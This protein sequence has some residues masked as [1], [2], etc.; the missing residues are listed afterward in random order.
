MIGYQIFTAQVLACIETAICNIAVIYS[1]FVPC[2]ATKVWGGWGPASDTHE[3]VIVSSSCKVLYVV[4]TCTDIL[5]LLMEV[6]T[7]T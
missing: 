4:H 2:Y 5:Y 1:L 7:L 6:Y 3:N